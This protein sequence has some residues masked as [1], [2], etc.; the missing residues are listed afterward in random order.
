MGHLS[1]Y[2]AVTS[3]SKRPKNDILTESEPMEVALQHRCSWYFNQQA[4]ER[5][6]M[7]CS[8]NIK[9]KGIRTSLA[10]VSR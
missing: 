3:R 1:T 5:A 8:W 10:K 7:K 2:S 6:R 4:E 9:G